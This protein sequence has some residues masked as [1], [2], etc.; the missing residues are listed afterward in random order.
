MYEE[1]NVLFLLDEKDAISA[2]EEAARQ[3]RKSSPLPSE[4][5]ALERFMGD[6]NI[7]HV[8]KMEMIHGF[9]EMS[10]KLKEFLVSDD[11]LSRCLCCQLHP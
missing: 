6:N 1:K 9:N 8:Q 2:Y 10:S 5:E 4:D 11:T 3:K 7:G